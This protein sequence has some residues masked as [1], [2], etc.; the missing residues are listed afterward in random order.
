MD[1]DDFEVM[2]YQIQNRDGSKIFTDM[3]VN[4][5]G[6]ILGFNYESS[7]QDNHRYE[8]VGEDKVGSVEVQDQDVDVLEGLPEVSANAAAKN[9]L[10]SLEEERAKTGTGEMH[11]VEDALNSTDLSYPEGGAGR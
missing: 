10:E 1:R 8:V 5:D 9:L 4:Y 11:D 3:G 6:E 7:S 2:D